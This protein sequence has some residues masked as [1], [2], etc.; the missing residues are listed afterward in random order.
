MSPPAKPWRGS[1][2]GGL[3]GTFKISIE[4]FGST[5][6]ILIIPEGSSVLSTPTPIPDKISVASYSG[7]GT[8]LDPDESEGWNNAGVTTSIFQANGVCTIEYTSASRFGLKIY[9]SEDDTLVETIALRPYGSERI[10]VGWN[11]G[12]TSIGLNGTHYF[13]I[14]SAGDW[15]VDVYCPNPNYKRKR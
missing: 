11:N 12:R 4:S 2:T 1:W 3:P 9:K 5:G 14:K 15:K 7:V 6:N 8:G 10:S 13:V